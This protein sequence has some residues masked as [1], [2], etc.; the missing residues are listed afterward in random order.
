VFELQQRREARKEA[1]QGNVDRSQDL[2]VILD[3]YK[4]YR[5]RNQIDALEAEAQMR[6]QGWS[7]DLVPDRCI[8]D[9]LFDLTQSLCRLALSVMCICFCIVHF[10]Y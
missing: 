10:T 8:Y 2:R 1:L 9:R 3:Y 5:E 4:R 6:K 7:T